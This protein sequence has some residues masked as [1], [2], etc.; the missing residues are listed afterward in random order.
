MKSASKN[1][2][3]YDLTFWLKI[4]HLAQVRFKVRFFCSLSAPPVAANADLW[5]DSERPKHLVMVCS[6][7]GLEG[8]NARS[9]PQAEES[10][11]KRG[12]RD[13]PR[14]PAPPQNVQKKSESPLDGLDG[15]MA[16]S[17]VPTLPCGN[18]GGSE[19]RVNEDIKEVPR[20]PSGGFTEESERD[21]FGAIKELTKQVNNL[22]FNA[23][24]KTDIANMQGQI[25]TEV[26]QFVKGAIS[27]SVDP[28]KDEVFDLKRRMTDIEGLRG[29]F[30]QR[31]ASIANSTSTTPQ[32][33]ARG[34]TVFFGGL[35]SVF[36]DAK[37]FI[38]EELKKRKL[39]GPREAYHKGDEFKGFMHYKY[40]DQNAANDV[41]EKLSRAKLFWDGRQIECKVDTP[42]EQRAGLG[43]ILGL[44]RLL[45]NWG[46]E[47]RN[48]KVDDYI[49]LLSVGGSP[50]VSAK[51]V[52]HRLKIDWLD[53]TWESWEELQKADMFLELVSTANKRLEDSARHS[54]KG[55]GK[56]FKGKGYK[57]P[58]AQ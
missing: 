5:T 33:S 34:S 24:T 43:F 58:R 23:A 42:I 12:A 27:E 40:N 56:G 7:C 32:L 29:E 47:R 49:P 30:E 4:E 48:L 38:D 31:V 1:G 17:S 37:R 52:E 50:V 21:L 10:S 22:T 41:V 8:H 15:V 2:D 6:V 55:G 13:S 35:G 53:P 51:I 44:R 18:A 3:L 11:N 14:T 45:I 25:V 36:E 19:K 28:I 39:Q 46:F 20:L 54:Q 57:G 9:C 26:K 16:D